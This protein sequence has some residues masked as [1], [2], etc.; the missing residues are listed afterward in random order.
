V[1][2]LLNLS[3]SRN[4]QATYAKVEAAVVTNS[5]AKGWQGTALKKAG[6]GGSIPSLATTLSNRK[7]KCLHALASLANLPNIIAGVH[8]ESKFLRPSRCSQRDVDAG[9]SRG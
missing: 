6:G 2:P 3:E 9:L 4:G 7:H 5:F 8:L 1:A